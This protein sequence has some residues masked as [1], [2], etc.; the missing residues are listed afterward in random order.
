M[1]EN[2]V[3]SMHVGKKDILLLISQVRDS[4]D[5]KFDRFGFEFNLVDTAGIRRKAKVK[6]FRVY[7]VMRSVRAIEHADICILIID[8]TRGFEGQDQSI[9][10]LAEKNRKGCDF[11]KQMGFS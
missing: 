2:Q 8:A 9:F 5:T 11:G 3:L 10:W 4:I 7:S 6:E 1:L